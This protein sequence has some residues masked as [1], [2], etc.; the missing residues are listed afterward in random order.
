MVV[1]T[2]AEI[3]LMDREALAEWT[4]RSPE[5]IRK[6]CTVV[7][8]GPGKRALYDAQAS[9]DLLRNVPRRSARRS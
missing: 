5:V 7:E 4:R 6:R 1:L 8:Y 9:A 2:R 3:V